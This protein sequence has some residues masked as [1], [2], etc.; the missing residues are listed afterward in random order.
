MSAPISGS[1]DIELQEV[2][3]MP[4]CHCMDKHALVMGV[5]IVALCAAAA[6]AGLENMSSRHRVSETWASL[7]AGTPVQADPE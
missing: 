7:P 1:V 5:V 3:M 4:S 6:A 2:N